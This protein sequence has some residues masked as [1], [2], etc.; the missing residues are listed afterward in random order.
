MSS[1]DMKGS[2]DG[3][4]YHAT[5]R[6]KADA[7]LRD[8]MPAHV[9]YWG[10]YEIAAYYAETVEDEGLVPVVL[11]VG[12]SDLEEAL[13]RPD[14]PG[15]EEPIAT[16]IGCREADVIAAWSA[17]EGT[18]RDCLDIVGSLT[19]SGVVPASALREE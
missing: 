18:W 10:V 5:S 19:F 15:I 4:L 6:E 16:V 17:C 8:G 2:F 9:S 1:A 14:M 3:R 12:L 13:L 11:S 7:F